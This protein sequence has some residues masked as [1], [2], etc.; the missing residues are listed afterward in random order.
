MYSGGSK[1]EPLKPNPI[2]NFEAY[3]FQKLGSLSKFLK[4]RGPMTPLDLPA[5]GAH[6][7]R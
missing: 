5:G 7:L 4:F 6:E 2:Q 3:R 1:S